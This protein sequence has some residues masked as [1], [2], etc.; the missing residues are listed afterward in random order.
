MTGRMP[1][2]RRHARLAASAISARSHS[3]SLRSSGVARASTAAR[4]LANL[5][6]EVR[7]G[8]GHAAR[9]DGRSRPSARRAARRPRRSPPRRAAAG[10]A[11]LGARRAPAG[12]RG[13]RARRRRR[14]ARRESRRARES[15]GRR[16]PAGAMRSARDAGLLRDLGRGREHPALAMHGHH[17]P[18]PGQPQPVGDLVAVRVA[19]RRGSAARA[20]RTTRAPRR[21]R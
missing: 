10:R 13:R 2:A 12:S 16:C 9:D 1:K 18:G 19:R 20:S 8:G 21:T 14:P 17:R 3:G 15:G 6:G 11:R 7:L 5:A 4:R